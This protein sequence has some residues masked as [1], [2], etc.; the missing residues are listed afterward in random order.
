MGDIANR[1]RSRV[2][3]EILG[4]RFGDP[5][6]SFFVARGFLLALRI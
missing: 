4:E 6:G 1:P 5:A 2:N 3:N